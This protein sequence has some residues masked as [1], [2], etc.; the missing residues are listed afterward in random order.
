MLIFGKID[1]KAKNF[2][3]DFLKSLL[4]DKG[5]NSSR[6]HNNPKCLRAL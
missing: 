5:V 1:R 2:T 4:N 3:K 6:E